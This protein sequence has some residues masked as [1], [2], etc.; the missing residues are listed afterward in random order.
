MMGVD[1][2]PIVANLFA[3]NFKM[4]FCLVTMWEPHSYEN[5]DKLEQEEREK[6]HEKDNSLPE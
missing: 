5:K 3:C 2:N 4:D 1:K 6:K